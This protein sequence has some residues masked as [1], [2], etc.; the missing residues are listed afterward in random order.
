[1]LAPGKPYSAFVVEGAA[2]YAVTYGAPDG[3]RLEVVAD[4]ERLWLVAE[5]AR[6]EL[7][8]PSH[9]P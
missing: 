7:Q 2:D 9:R 1:V 3:Q 8:P 4:G 6:I 5:G